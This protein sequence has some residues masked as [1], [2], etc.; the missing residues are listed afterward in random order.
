[1]RR[2][3]RCEKSRPG[4]ENQSRYTTARN[5]TTESATHVPRG[6]H[7]PHARAPV[8]SKNARLRSATR[9]RTRKTTTGVSRAAHRMQ[10]SALGYNNNRRGDPAVQ[11]RGEVKSIAYCSTRRQCNAMMRQRQRRRG[12]RFLV[13]RGL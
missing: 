5:P 6:A 12:G 8:A 1:M 3:S 2:T 13:R 7:S 11:W 10:R 9:A 4:Q